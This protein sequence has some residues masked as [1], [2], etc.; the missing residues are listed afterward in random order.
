MHKIS[1]PSFLRWMFILVICTPLSVKAQTF[2]LEDIFLTNKLSA[3]RF[4]SVSWMKDGRFYSALIYDG[5]SQ[6]DILVKYDITSGDMTD[7]LFDP[8]QLKWPEG[9]VP[10]IG[11]YAFNSTEEKIL[12]KTDVEQIYRRSSVAVFYIY[13]INSGSIQKLNESNEKISYATFSPDG[14]NIAYVKNNNL[15]YYNLANNKH[16]AI[17]RDGKKNEII[18]GAADW[19][20][21]EEFSMS[22]AFSW[23]P[24]GQMV[25]FL[26]FDERDVP[27]YNMQLWGALYP[28]DYRFKYPKAGETNSTVSLHVYDLKNGETTKIESGEEPDIYIPRMYWVP[29][30]QMLSFIKLNRLQ[31]DLKIIHAN[32]N[33]GDTNEVYHETSGT[34]VDMD[35]TDD[36]T[37]TSDGEAFFKTSEKDGFKHIYHYSIEGG[38]ISQVTEGNWEVSELIGIDEKKNTIYYISTED[39]PLERHLYSIRTDGKKKAKIT[40]APGIHKTD[41]S[42]DFKYFVDTFSNT[43]RPSTSVLYESGGKEVKILERNNSLLQRAANYQLTQR[44]FFELKIQDS[45]TLHGY[46]IK[47][48][49]FD[50]TK[51]YPVLMHVY[52]GPGNQTV[53]N[54]WGGTR[55]MWHQYIAQKGYLIVSIDNRGTDGRGVDFKHS[56]Y[57]Q[58]GKLEVLDQIAGARFLQTLPYVDPDRIGIWGWSYGGYMSALALF[59]GNDVFNM[60]ISVAPVTN[61]R[62][63]DTIYTERYQGLPQENPEGY[64]AF[65]P[66]NHAE[67]LKGD[68]LL[69]HGTGDDNVHF[70]NSVHLQQALIDANKQFRSFYYPN[71]NHGMSTRKNRL[72]LYQ[73]MTDFVLE[74]L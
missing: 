13:D 41:F 58:M 15:Y 27:E 3:D 23:S 44:T 11:D 37:Y 35:Y 1:L 71:A 69:I 33:T 51:Q 70:Q 22:K 60:A 9:D 39:S 5:E 43:E 26:R 45:T 38:L 34:F 6:N 52:G 56:T 42:P 7:I 28:K 67:K 57:A 32:P 2:T 4:G 19:V 66:I 18:N 65:S 21:E 10:R 36:L 46:M 29:Q 20:Y 48:V 53:Q 40:Q 63:Y 59:V 72:H 47:P 73:M 61:W 54:E 49:D 31:N 62:F 55:E 16:L 12:L 24:D 30:K 74:K 50:S 17:T 64:D 68:L 25:A 8:Q 14:G